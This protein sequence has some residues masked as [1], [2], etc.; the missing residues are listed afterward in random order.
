MSST[1]IAILATFFGGTASIVVALI[2]IVA[3]R[4]FG[5]PG[6]AQQVD[7]E[8]EKLIALYKQERDDALTK[9][10]D[11]Q[12]RIEK[13]EERCEKLEKDNE[14]LEGK[15]RELR[16][17]LMFTESELLD[18]YRKQGVRPPKRLATRVA[19]Q[20]EPDGPV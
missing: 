12:G 5:L 2:G 6:L 10:N 8:Q 11:L 17:E 19:E 13:A 9:V 18:L 1:E 14:F 4:R 15:N 7:T 20:E 3:S 16:R